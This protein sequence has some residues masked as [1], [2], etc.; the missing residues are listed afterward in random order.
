[1][2][3]AVATAATACD[4]IAYIALIVKAFAV[5]TFVQ[6]NRSIFGSRARRA[7]Y[8]EVDSVPIER[9]ASRGQH[10]K[11]WRSVLW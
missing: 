10:A 4:T 8:D 1:M 3:A 9:S 7:R 5:R 6:V 11:R 2:G